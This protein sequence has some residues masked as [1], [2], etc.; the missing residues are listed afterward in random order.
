M[1]FQTSWTCD[2][3]AKKALMNHRQSHAGLNFQPSNREVNARF[4]A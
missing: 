2:T 4:Q 1:T 3:S